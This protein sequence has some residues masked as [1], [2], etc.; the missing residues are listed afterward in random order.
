MNADNP[1]IKVGEINQIGVVVKDLKK[2]LENYWKTLG[3][4]PWRIH[5]F[6]PGS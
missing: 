2:A 1:K 3:I 4:G 5:T 6:A